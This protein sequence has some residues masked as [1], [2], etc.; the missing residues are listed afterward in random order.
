M[1]ITRT[2]ALLTLLA[3]PALADPPTQI[4]PMGAPG[5]YAIRKPGEPTI[6]VQP[7]GRGGFSE[8]QYGQ[9]TVH[10]DPTPGGGWRIW[11][12]DKPTSAITIPPPR[13]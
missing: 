4:G 7:N 9:P 1:K 12:E 10:H 5:G 3:F 11:S 8:R 13:K 6:S 2:A